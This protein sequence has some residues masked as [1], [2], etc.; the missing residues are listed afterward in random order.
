[1]R[2]RI[3]TSFKV[4]LSTYNFVVPIKHKK[5]TF[6]ISNSVCEVAECKQ[7]KC[8]QPL[9]ASA[10][11]FEVFFAT[12]LT[13]NNQFTLGL[14]SSADEDAEFNHHSLLAH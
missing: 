4:I 13:G 11:S 1:M 7:I 14:V 2:I 6:F 3:V 8:D 12:Q 10:C 5:S 9:L